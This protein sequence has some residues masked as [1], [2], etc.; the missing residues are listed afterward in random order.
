MEKFL[1]TKLLNLF[2]TP[3][4]SL[5]FLISFSPPT[6][7]SNLDEEPLEEGV[8]IVKVEGCEY[9]ISEEEIIAWLSL[10]GEVV[11]EIEEDFYYLSSLFPYCIQL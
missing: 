7:Q 4:W 9:R 5:V 11:S 1:R 2:L 6:T 8:K 10:Y 3:N